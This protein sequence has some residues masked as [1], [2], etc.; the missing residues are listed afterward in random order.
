MHE[1]R[2]QR[3]APQ[4]WAWLGTVALVAASTVLSLLAAE[5]LFRAMP[6][7]SGVKQGKDGVAYRFNPF[8]PD[9]FVAFALREGASAVHATGNFE[10][11]V[12]INELGFRGPPR[13]ASKPPAPYRILMLGDSFAFGWGVEYE[14]SFGARLERRLRSASA[15]V[16]VLNAG[17]PGWSA[18]DQ[19]IFLERRGPGLDPDLV[20]L[21]ESENDPDDLRWKDLELDDRLLPVRARSTHRAVDHRGR[22]RTVKGVPAMDF[23]GEEWLRS[24]SYLWNA[25]RFR[26]TKLHIIRLYGQAEVIDPAQEEALLARPLASL[27]PSEL[28]QGLRSSPQFR[29]AYHRRLRRAIEESL[30]SQGIPL[31]RLLVTFADPGPYDPLVLEGLH[32]DCASSGST[33][34]DT[35]DFFEDAEQSAA[36]F[37][38]DGHWTSFGHQRVADRLVAWLSG[39]GA[40]LRLEIAADRPRQEVEAP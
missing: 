30:R 23:P 6:S 18:D 38:E 5:V 32:G 39:Q 28:Q 37:P 24:H 26:L 9:P 17:V 2:V 35:R 29:L 10:V 12:E 3:D 40:A 7:W 19:L 22:L 13:P 34:L 8:R 31:R 21:A 1:R 36:F 14:A 27:E 25:L 16:E 11:V 20:L 4:G 33:C 15:E